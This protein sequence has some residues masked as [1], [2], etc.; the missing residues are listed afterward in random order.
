MLLCLSVHGP[1]ALPEQKS[2]KKKFNIKTQQSAFLIS[3]YVRE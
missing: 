1:F 2:L 3:S